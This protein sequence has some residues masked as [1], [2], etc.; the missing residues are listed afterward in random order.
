MKKKAA[1][2]VI[3]D[4][5]NIKNI[6]IQLDL[7]KNSTM[8]YS[9]FSPWE[10]IGLIIEGLAITAKE[11]IAEGVDRKKV[12][13]AINEYMI[14]ALPSYEILEKKKKAD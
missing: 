13:K 3:K 10:N 2:L 7:K 4:G 14:K 11:C 6:F 1:E 5:K 8:V 12:Y 9:N